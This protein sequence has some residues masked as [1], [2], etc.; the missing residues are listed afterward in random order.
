M[1]HTMKHPVTVTVTGA[2]G[3][4]GYA[5]LFRIAAGEMLGADTPVRLRLLEI[6]AG[7]KAAEGTAMELADCAFPLVESIDVTDDPNTGFE[8]ANLALLIGSRPRTKGMERADLLEAN[9]GIFSVQGRAINDRAA[10]DIKVAVVGNPA[11]TNALIAASHAPDVPLERFTALTRLDHHRAVAQLALA[12]GSPVDQIEG[13]AIWGNHS[14]SQYPDLFHATVA[15]RS[16]VDLLTQQGLGQDWVENTFIPKV[17]NRGAEVI[18]VRGGS[19]VAS[20]AHAALMHVH[21]WVLGTGESWTSMAVPSDGSYGVAEGI[22]SSFPV[23]CTGGVY[24]IIHGLEHL[25]F[26]QKRIAAS[27]AELV[28]EKQAVASLG[29]LGPR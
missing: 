10:D 17:A 14:A 2:A 24:E 25:D 15:G 8:G 28:E 29:L 11:N 3:Q 5:S 27:V 23:R 19:S 4:I 18:S 12:T 7:L 16:A 9:G 13:V 26:S 21:D 6:P 1:T 22:I 20:A